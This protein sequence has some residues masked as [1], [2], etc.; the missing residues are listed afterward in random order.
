[1]TDQPKTNDEKTVVVIETEV[2][3][4]VCGYYM[5]VSGFNEGKKQEF[6]DRVPVRMEAGDHDA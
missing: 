1:M 6:T 5:P 2:Y 4:R 3:S